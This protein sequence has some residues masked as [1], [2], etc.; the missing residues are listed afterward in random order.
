MS[1]TQTI[2]V[3]QVQALLDEGKSR[4]EIAE[5]LGVTQRYARDVIFQ[6]PKLKGRKAKK[7]YD[8]NFVDDTAEDFVAADA[9]IAEEEVAQTPY[10]P[11][12]VLPSMESEEEEE[13]D[14]KEEDAVAAVSDEEAVNAPSWDN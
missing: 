1:S 8:I 10:P 12:P 6:H 13:G 2:T 11:Q 7:Q 9:A 4:K 5:E 14:D 3:S